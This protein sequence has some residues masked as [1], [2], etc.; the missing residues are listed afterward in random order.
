MLLC[1]YVPQQDDDAAGCNLPFKTEPLTTLSRTT[2]S[3]DVTNEADGERRSWPAVDAVDDAALP[4]TR[5]AAVRRNPSSSATAEKRCC[6]LSE[7]SSAGRSSTAGGVLLRA[8]R[9]AHRRR[10]P[11]TRMAGW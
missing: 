3:A 4:P 9:G 5:A 1:D 10:A 6:H 8:R 11:A 7:S 2:F